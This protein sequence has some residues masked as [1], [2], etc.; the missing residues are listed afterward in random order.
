MN[1]DT[2]IAVDDNI[3]EPKISEANLDEIIKTIEMMPNDTDNENS[4]K[5]KMNVEEINDNIESKIEENK[6]VPINFYNN[7]GSPKRESEL[8]AQ[9]ISLRDAFIHHKILIGRI[10]GVYRTKIGVYLM[11]NHN[12][13][14]I[15]IH[16]NNTNIQT[17]AFE[18]S[19]RNQ[20]LKGSPNLKENQLVALV[21]KAYEQRVSQ[22]IGS[23]VRF[24]IVASLESGTVRV[25]GSKERA[26]ARRVR[27]FYLGASTKK[28]N[29]GTTINSDIVVVTD[30]MLIVDVCGVEARI[31]QSN[32][33]RSVESLTESYS[34]GD[35]LPVVVTSIKGLEEFDDTSMKK[36]I[37]TYRKVQI[38]ARSQEV[39][40]QN[41]LALCECY[42]TGMSVMGTVAS[43]SDN[44][45]YTLYLPNGAIA[46]CYGSNEMPPASKGDKLLI[47]VNS[48]DKARVLVRGTI[49]R[50][51]KKAR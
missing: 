17:K 31:S 23:T 50:L 36:M 3:D 8:S 37:E 25:L 27:N 35:K 11:V 40:N 6:F 51:V 30:N 42:K 2:I 16:I 33:K 7:D 45:I 46:R 39:H 44:G 26:D 1:E 49:I 12:N 47:S 4:D 18:A 43:A 15:Y 34:V 24:E 48:I 9:E 19:L 5:A 13:S 22:R 20:L 38:T 29:V 28:I 41:R 32:V 21:N 14:I 10:D